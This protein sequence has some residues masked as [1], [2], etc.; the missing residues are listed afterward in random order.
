MLIIF[1][2]HILLHLFVNFL[3]QFFFQFFLS[4]AQFPLKFQL[5]LGHRHIQLLP[6]INAFCFYAGL[7]LAER[8]RLMLLEHAF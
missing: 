3:E 7:R 6:G 1:R 4:L 8:F 5:G 2:L